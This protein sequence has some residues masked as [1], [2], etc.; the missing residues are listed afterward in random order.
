MDILGAGKFR[1]AEKPGRSDGP[2]IGGRAD[3]G[4]ALS[5]FGPVGILAG[6]LFGDV[7]IDIG[8]RGIIDEGTVTGDTSLGA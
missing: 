1:M 6:R 3:I 5:A 4:F 8:L 2:Y 7:F